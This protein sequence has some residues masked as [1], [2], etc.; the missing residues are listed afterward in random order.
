MVRRLADLAQGVR[1]LVSPEFEWVYVVL[2]APCVGSFL[3]ALALRLP[4]GASVVVGRSRCDYCHETLGLRDL[5]PVVSW[6]T[7]RGRCRHCNVALGTFYPAIEIGAV[8]IAAWAAVETSGW[9]LWAGCFLGWVLLSLAVIDSR[10]FILP[11]ELVLPLIPAGLMAS[12]AIDPALLLHHLVGALAGYAA[13]SLT[14]AAYGRL[15]GREGLGLGDA[16]LMAAAGAWLSWQSLPG[17]VLIAVL[18]AVAGLAAGVLLGRRYGPTDRLP[19]GTC[20]CP[21]IWIVWM[22][23]PLQFG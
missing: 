19:F 11:D 20:I 7:L 21:A 22:Y 9:L 15:R 1:M 5:F 14:R 23:G 4:L 8:A 10:H 18:I 13:F 16:K 2:V 3:G 17:V 12:W 6:L